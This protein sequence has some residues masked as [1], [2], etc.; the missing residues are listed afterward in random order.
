MKKFTTL[1]LSAFALVIVCSSFVPKDHTKTRAIE[2]VYVFGFSFSFNDST[3]YFTDIQRID[4]AE[5]GSHGML[6]K[7]PVF[8]EQMRNHL[9]QS[10][11][12]T[13]TCA[14]FFSSNPKK[15]EKQM[16]K[17]MKHYEKKNLL[18]RILPGDEFS[19]INI[20]D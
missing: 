12:P 11:V 5:T 8:S 20:P 18:W 3:I 14:I 16:S 13:P 15:V 19:F 4:S 9:M 6:M 17:I 7:R 2:T 1:L 10:G